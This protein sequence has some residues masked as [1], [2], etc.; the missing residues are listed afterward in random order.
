MVCS[1][2]VKDP[3]LG[4]GD[5]YYGDG[6][7][8]EVSGVDGAL[9]LMVEVPVE[10]HQSPLLRVRVVDKYGVVWGRE[11]KL[12]VVPQARV[13]VHGHVCLVEYLAWA[14]VAGPLC[15]F[16]ADCGYLADLRRV[17]VGHAVKEEGGVSGVGRFYLVPYGV[18]I[19]G[20]CRP[21]GA[22]GYGGGQAPVCCPCV[23]DGA[24]GRLEGGGGPCQVES[25]EAYGGVQDPGEVVRQALVG[26][27]EALGGRG[28]IS[29]EMGRCD[30][31]LG[32]RVASSGLVAWITPTWVVV[33][34]TCMGGPCGPRVGG[35]ICGAYA[36][37]FSGD[38]REFIL[39]SSF[40]P[41]PY[42]LA[43]WPRCMWYPPTMRGAPRDPPV[44]F[45]SF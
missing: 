30:C 40:I 43:G 26:Q 10:D 28:R 32:G 41:P 3:H 25:L 2:V 5:V 42:C 27:A 7:P 17:V 44:L 24:C 38:R 37:R 11:E 1:A 19:V 8:D 16:E 33:V 22:G 36:F 14:C 18:P 34:T 31:N 15:D 21:D 39:L 45:L 29:E 35:V 9:G 20:P 13:H 6:G 23:G 12:Q 4:E